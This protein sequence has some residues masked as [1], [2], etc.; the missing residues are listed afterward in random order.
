MLKIA[1]LTDIHHGPDNALVQ[2][3]AALPLLEHSL[4][5]LHQQSPD[6]L[7]DLGDRISDIS[8]EFDAERMAQVASLFETLSLPRHHLLGNHDVLPHAEQEELLAVSL[9]PHYVDMAGWRL[10]FLYSFDSSIRGALSRDDLAWL[11]RTLAQSTFPAIIFSHQPLDGI[12]IEGN[13]LFTGN[14]KEQVHPHGHEEARRIMEASGKVRLAVNGHTHW[15]QS[16][17][18]SGISYLTIPSLVPSPPQEGA[19]PEAA[20][21]LLTLADESAMVNVYGRKP[22]EAKLAVDSSLSS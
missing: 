17:Q 1:L 3:G 10:V 18:V 16:V 5:A 15:N 12:P 22:F 6:V 20:Y 21:A 19:K 7:I 11:G 2:G 14:L 8:S 13:P 9:E 4:K